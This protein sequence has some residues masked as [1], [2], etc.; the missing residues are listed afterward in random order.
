MQCDTEETGWI[1]RKAV[2]RSSS[3]FHSR[4]FVG[5]EGVAVMRLNATDHSYSWVMRFSSTLTGNE[6]GLYLNSEL[7]WKN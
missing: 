4:Q 6:E 3:G 7:I 2:V 5:R 1:G